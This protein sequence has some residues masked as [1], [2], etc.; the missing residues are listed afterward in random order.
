[1]A[2]KIRSFILNHLWPHRVS[3]TRYAVVG[4]T[5]FA[6]D[7]GLLILLSDVLKW[8][9]VLAVLVIQFIVIIYNF[10]LNKYWSFSSRLW[11]HSQVVKYLTLVGWNYIFSF[12]T[13]FFF[14]EIMGLHYLLVRLATVLLMVSWNFALYKWWVYR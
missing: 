4:S 8:K 2:K 6:L 1:M 13:M 11:K 9:P 3:F 14:N 12:L 7:I 10:L 5:G